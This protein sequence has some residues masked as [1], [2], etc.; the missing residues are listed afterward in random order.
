MFVGVDELVKLRAVS[1]Q[2]HTS[3]EY[4]WISFKGKGS[5]HLYPFRLNA[6]MLMRFG[7]LSLNE[8]GVRWS[9][10]RQRDRNFQKSRCSSSSKNPLYIVKLNCSRV[11]HE[12]GKSIPRPA[13][14]TCTV[15]LATTIKL[16]WTRLHICFVRS[17]K[18][19]AAKIFLTLKY[20]LI[21]LGPIYEFIITRN[22]RRV[23]K[24]RGSAP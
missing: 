23:I 18:G 7:E 21:S 20:S 19:T 10:K 24:N 3:P 1:H 16:S 6:F 9:T 5:Q 15:Y 11:K 17:W 14:P 4:I 13:R 2:R 12:R 22:L 8:F